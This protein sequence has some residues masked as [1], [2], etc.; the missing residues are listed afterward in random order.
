M[1]RPSTSIPAHT[2][3]RTRHD[4]ADHHR[5]TGPRRGLGGVPRRAV[6]RRRGGRPGHRL[7][8][9]G[10]GADAVLGLGASC[11]RRPACRCPVR[12]PGAARRG[13]GPPPG[14]GGP[15]RTARRGPGGGPPGAARLRGVGRRG[16]GG[17]VGDHRGGAAGRAA[18]PA[19][20]RG[21]RRVDGRTHPAAAGRGPLHP[22]VPPRP[23]LVV[24]AVRQCRRMPVSWRRWAGSRQG[25]LSS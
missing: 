3:T 5:R 25:R 11:L 6:R 16:H 15:G 1:A 22:G 7:R 23:R 14:G 8:L 9:G 20:A 13:R 21:R 24:T 19:R 17:D 2:E 10:P 12:P 4:R 18:A